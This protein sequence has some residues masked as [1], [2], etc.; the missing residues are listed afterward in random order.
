MEL[1]GSH[2][3]LGVLLENL[4]KRAEAETAYHNARKILKPLV[5]DFPTVPN[6]RHYLANIHNNLGLLLR[7]TGQPAKAE[8]AFRDAL[9]IG[10]QLAAD[11]PTVSHYAV[12]LGGSYCNLGN[13][14]K[15]NGQPQA[16]LDWFAQAIRTLDAVLAKDQGNLGARQF[17]RNAHWSRAEALTQ[18]GRY[19]E[20]VHDWDR[21]LE[22]DEGAGRPAL[23]LQRASTLVRAGQAAQAVVEADA[24][25]QG[26]D[27]PGETLY[28]T[29]CLYALAS[30][31]LK[32]NSQQAET[33]AAKAV[34]LLRRAQAA[35]YFQKPARIAH[36]KKDTDLDS[37]RNRAD[38]RA[39][40]KLLEEKGKP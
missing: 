37:L 4:G 3:N 32:D 11:F 38:Y 21:A 7:T 18:L 36:M 23:R 26:K 25:T 40:V 2:N 20:A 15:D 30:A 9:K 17:L 35:G 29:A 12:A 31:A 5:A 10:E 22:L 19:A 28:D 13:L 14:V 39:L 33:Y 34:A 27:V 24:L 1:A 6:Y 16:A 8:T